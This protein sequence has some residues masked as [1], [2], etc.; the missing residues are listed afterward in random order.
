M[1]NFWRAATDN[2]RGNQAQVR[3]AQWKLA[4]LYAFHESMD[5]HKHDDGLEIIFNYNL[6][7]MQFHMQSLNTSSTLMDKF[8]LQ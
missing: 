3:M 1:P 8:M 2:D 6:N 5:I 7:T 4:S